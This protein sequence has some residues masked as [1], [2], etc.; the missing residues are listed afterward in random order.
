MG[1]CA[2]F[3]DWDSSER[4]FHGREKKPP[5][6]T[7]VL[8]W[9]LLLI[10]CTAF[11]WAW[12][13]EIDVVVKATGVLRPQSNMSTIRNMIGGK[14]KTVNM[15]E[16]N[17]V[18]QGDLLLEIDTE[19]IDYKLDSLAAELVELEEQLSGLEQLRCW[20]IRIAEAWDQGG[21]EY[22]DPA[23]LSQ[24][25]NQC[26][27]DRP[28]YHKAIY[29]RFLS[30][31]TQYDQLVL[32]YQQAEASV[33]K[34]KRTNT[35]PEHELLRLE[36]EQA[37]AELKVNNYLHGSIV[38]VDQEV[39]AKMDRI[40]SIKDQLT[41]LKNTKLLSQVCAPITGTIQVYSQINAGE[42]LPSGYE[43]ARIIPDQKYQFCV[44]ISVRN[45]DIALIEAGQAIVYRFEALPRH[46]FGTVKGRITGIAGDALQ[47]SDGSLV[48]RVFGSVEQTTLKDHYSNEVEL[49]PGMVC[50]SRIAIKRE[51]IIYWLLQRLGFL[52]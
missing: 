32:A 18:N 27:P 42:Y 5:W 19:V 47:A 13:G 38:A 1:R 45:Q 37:A 31:K 12:F 16:G 3:V 29:H 39:A 9:L 40:K 20:M 46:Q 34:H 30:F 52:N 44:E 14:V 50:Q 43:V 28:D 36:L 7:A 35:L 2:A 8:V 24:L 11:L 48:Y 26:H 4:G 33:T 15:K 10:I 22:D 25:C 6:Y 41:E 49:K 17:P 51:K 23:W 21:S